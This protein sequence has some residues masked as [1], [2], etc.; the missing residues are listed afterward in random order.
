V[1]P[2]RVLEAGRVNNPTLRTISRYLMAVGAPFS[3]FSDLLP[4]LPPLPKLEPKPGIPAAVIKKTEKEAFDYQ[5]KTAQPLRG[6]PMEP[7]THRVAVEKYQEKRL[8]A[9]KVA[10]ALKLALNNLKMGWLERRAC[11][12]LGTKLLSAVNRERATTERTEKKKR[13][14]RPGA[15]EVMR[16][17]CAKHGLRVELGEAV[18]KTVREAVGSR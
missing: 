1:S 9:N 7:A 2:T 13:A 11:E 10:A 16:E 15:E 17:F 8:E 5:L 6:A 14:Q 12:T 18:L 4:P 3:A